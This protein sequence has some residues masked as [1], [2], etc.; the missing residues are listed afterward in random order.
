MAKI[1]HFQFSYTMLSNIKKTLFVIPL[2]IVLFTSCKKEAQSPIDFDEFIFDGAGKSYAL[3]NNGNITN[4][5]LFAYL[6]IPAGAVTEKNNIEYYKIYCDTSETKNMYVHWYLGH[7][8]FLS[9]SA[10][11]LQ[12][13]ATIKIPMP[14][15]TYNATNPYKPY[16]IKMGKNVNAATAINNIANRTLITDYTW[17]NIGKFIVIKTTDLNAAYIMARPK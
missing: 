14:Y 9:S 1:I 3:S 6:E 7:I 11:T 5:A 2:L 13:P 17:D 15:N 8:H 16:K 10:Q 4:P 12:I